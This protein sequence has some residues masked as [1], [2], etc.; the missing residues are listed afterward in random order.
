MKYCRPSFRLILKVSHALVCLV[1]Y[2]GQ[3]L[4]GRIRLLNEISNVDSLFRTF[5]FRELYSSEKFSLV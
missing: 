3:S 5:C 2:L 4:H 1:Y